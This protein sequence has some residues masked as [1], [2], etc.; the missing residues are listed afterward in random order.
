MKRLY[1]KEIILLLTDKSK[2]NDHA[3][4]VL[5][6]TVARKSYNSAT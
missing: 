1:E 5:V 2:I 6:K 3:K 4:K